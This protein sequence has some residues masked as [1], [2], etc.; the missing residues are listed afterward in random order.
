MERT[1]AWFNILVVHQ[2]R[3]AKCGP[4]NHIRSDM[5]PSWMDF[6]L[7]GHEHESIPSVV[8][9]I[10]SDGGVL[11]ILQLGSTVSRFLLIVISIKVN[12][13]RWRLR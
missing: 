3:Y 10:G 8:D 1:D 6:V 2:N 9:A 4:K 13:F 7:W 5:L 11:R 12:P